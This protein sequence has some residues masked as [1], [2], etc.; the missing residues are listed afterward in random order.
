[1]YWI[2]IVGGSLASSLGLMIS[3]CILKNKNYRNIRN[4]I[5][6]FFSTLSVTLTNHYLP[7]I[8]KMLINIMVS[9]ILSSYLICD[10]NIKEGIIYTFSFFIFSTLEEI[11]LAIFLSLL[12]KIGITLNLNNYMLLFSILNSIFIIYIIRI[13]KI[14]KLIYKLLEYNKFIYFMLIFIFTLLV[15]IIYKYYYVLY[16]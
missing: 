4:I 13:N 11:I 9:I 16:N 1:M 2:N 6:L 14:K 5:F 3:F 7:G 10:K 15:F 12:L 8:Q